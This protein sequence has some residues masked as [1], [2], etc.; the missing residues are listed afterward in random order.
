MLRLL[1]PLAAACILAAGASRAMPV[2]EPVTPDEK[3]ALLREIAASGR[4]KVG[5]VVAPTA[6]A[7]FTVL[8]ASG[9][10]RGVPAALGEALA[11]EL[12]IACELVSAPNSGELASRLAE[13]T[14]DLAFLPVD[15]DRRRMVAFGPAYYQS[16][17]TYLVTAGSGIVRL[18]E[19]DRPG[20]R[21]LGI[22]NTTTIRS[23]ARSLS[24]TSITPVASVEEAMAQLA[25]NQADALALGRSSMTA[26]AASLPGSRILDGGFLRNDTALALPHGRPRA[27]AYA[28][29]FI[30]RAKKSGLVRR[31]FD[32]AGLKSLQVAP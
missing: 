7:S 30:E 24:R 19:V 17:S 5:V 29:A 28:A 13:G 20:V 10:P 15:D 1:L 14:I 16:E 3:A 22:A 25:S 18:E 31:A 21:V 23:A 26:L 27:L 11:Q 2:H 8:D 4:L 9:R 6:G 12:G 32:N